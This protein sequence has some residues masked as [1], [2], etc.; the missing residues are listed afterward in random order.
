MG[1]IETRIDR[2]SPEFE[3]NTYYFQQLIDQLNERIRQVQQGGGPDAIAK[4][5]KRNK[6]LARERIHLL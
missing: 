1:I 4:H 2:N 3:E 5:R 6:L